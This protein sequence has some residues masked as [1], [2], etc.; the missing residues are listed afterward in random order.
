M[1]TDDQSCPINLVD[2]MSGVFK[3]VSDSHMQKRQAEVT[4]MRKVRTNLNDSEQI[5]GPAACQAARRS[6][7]MKRVR[8][9]MHVCL[10]VCVCV[11]T[12]SDWYI[13]MTVC[14]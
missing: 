8:A 2:N 7:T 13:G 5:H 12:L 14:A 11:S 1:R 3:P 9:C 4:A 10:Y 6:C